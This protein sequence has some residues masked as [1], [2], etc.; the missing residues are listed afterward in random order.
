MLPAKNRLKISA[1]NAQSS[2]TFK[3]AD[4]N[5]LVIFKKTK[6]DFKTSV[7]ISKKVAKQAVER[8]RIKRITLEAISKL[9]LKNGQLQIIAKKNIAKMKTQ[10]VIKILNQ[11]IAKIEKHDSQTR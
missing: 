1:K 3:T 6:S 4:E 7:K 5:F 11:L 9:E 2:E 8:N 10:E